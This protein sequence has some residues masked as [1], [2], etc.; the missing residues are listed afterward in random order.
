MRRVLAF[1]TA[2]EAVAVAVGTWPDEAEAGHPEVEAELDFVARRAANTKLL[3]TVHAALRA[4]DLAPA[5]LD[6]V[7]VGRGPGSFT[8]VR[9]GVATAKGLAQGLGVPLYGAGTPDAVAQRFA[10]HDG[11]VGVVMDAM[12][13]E[14]YPTL[15]RCGD[16]RAERLGGYTVTTPEEAARA[17]AETTEGPMLLAGDALGRYADVFTF[18][19][20]TRASIAPEPSWLPGGAGLLLAAFSAEEERGS[21]HPGELLPVYTRLAD[22]EEN[23]A[24]RAGR[25]PTRPES[26]VAG[27]ARP[28]EPNGADRG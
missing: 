27:P 1:D 10:E 13:Q 12:R 6:A 14:V 3:P 4:L 23:E 9:I 21:G 24:K 5:D 20:G 8:G 26:G 19:L 22:A 18:A 25:P 7:V 15:F 2:T 16:G 11:L 28:D 17:W